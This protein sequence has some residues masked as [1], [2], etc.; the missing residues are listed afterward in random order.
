MTRALFLISHPLGAWKNGADAA[1]LEL[2]AGLR[3]RGV[4]VRFA[5][6][7]METPALA[8]WRARLETGDLGL[9]PAA[10]ALATL[11]VPSTHPREL[12]AAIAA[13][14]A[15]AIARLIEAAAPDVVIVPWGTVALARMARATHPRVVLLAQH[16]SA[17]ARY[18]ADELVGIEVAAMEPGVAA[19]M[20]TRLARPVRVVLNPIA[21]PPGEAA[22]PG[23]RIGMV[24]FCAE[25]GAVVFLNVAANLP[26]LAF[27][28]TGGW[29]GRAAAYPR[30]AGAPPNLAL[31]PATDDMAGFYRSLRMLL[32]PSLVDEAFGRVAVEAAAAGVPVVCT[33]R[34]PAARWSAALVVD[35]PPRPDEGSDDDLHDAGRHAAVIRGFLDA[36]VTLADRDNHAI[37]A[38][39]ARAAAATYLAAQ[40]RSLDDLA[41]WLG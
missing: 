3:A 11:A 40:Q 29:A 14:T 7:L 20:A 28:A 27:V 8:P 12:A 2:A 15:P 38:A 13:A 33:S 35:A 10:V 39:A 30:I 21:P 41:A 5:A 24:N 25:K 23:D 26:D 6:V 37:A 22:P 4:V 16:G 1:T 18:Q 31:V 36:V 32:V 34:C 19:A 9:D 17:A